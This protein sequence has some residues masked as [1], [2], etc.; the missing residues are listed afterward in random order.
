MHTL[1]GKA[2]R[3]TKIRH[4]SS[5]HPNGSEEIINFSTQFRG[6]VGEISRGG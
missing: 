4:G 1:R 6:L 3:S 2:F 5:G